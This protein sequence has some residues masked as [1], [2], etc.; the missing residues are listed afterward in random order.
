MTLLIHECFSIKCYK[1]YKRLL[2]PNDMAVQLGT[3]SSDSNTDLDKNNN[4]KKKAP[5]IKTDY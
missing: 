4:E 1:L 2:R 3:P 5:Q